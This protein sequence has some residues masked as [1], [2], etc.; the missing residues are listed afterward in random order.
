MQSWERRCVQR[1]AHVGDLVVVPMSHDDELVGVLRVRPVNDRLRDDA[2]L[3]V[4]SG[5]A[6]I[7]A[8]VA[9]RAR[10]ADAERDRAIDAERERLGRDL[11]DTLSQAL[12]GICLNLDECAV[13]SAEPET[14][15]RLARLRSAV[16]QANSEV[17]Q[18][19]HALSF[20]DRGRDGLVPSLRE[21][22]DGHGADG[23]TLTDLRV[24]G[25]PVALPPAR[26]EALYRVAHEALQNVRRHSNASVALV[27]LAYGKD[28]VSLTVC[29]DGDGISAAVSDQPGLHFGLRT[30][31]RRMEE[32]GG[33]LE[34][35]NAAPRGVLVA[36]WVGVG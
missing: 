13:A 31:R 32:V 35:R 9:L 33:G 26:E 18:A 23:G 12:F 22:V 29:D 14:R 10:I 27:E 16:S 6:G 4:A 34:V 20:L 21:L 11:H 36:A 25:T 3:A 19:I 17:R 5:L 8:R 7:L 2:L 15:E 1:P 28:R 30:M 24:T